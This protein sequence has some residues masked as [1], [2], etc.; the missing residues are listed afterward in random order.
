M[1]NQK[2]SNFEDVQLENKCLI[3]GLPKKYPLWMYHTAISF[4]DYSEY[5]LSVP[6]PMLYLDWSD[7]H[8]HFEELGL[9]I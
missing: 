2:N 1:L 8:I 6:L 9:V 4:K 5:S 3:I 7:F